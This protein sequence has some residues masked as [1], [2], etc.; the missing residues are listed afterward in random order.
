MGDVV[1]RVDASLEIGTGHVMRCLALAEALGRR[2]VTSRFIC[3]D[4][5]GHLAQRISRHGHRV[6]LL[7]SGACPPAQRASGQAGQPAHVAWLGA[8][9]KTDASQSIAMLADARPDWLVID[10]YA[11]DS[12]WEQALRPFCRR[13]MAID[14]LADRRHDVN[15]LLDQNLGRSADDYTGLLPTGSTVLAGARY[16]LL[17]P[18]FSAWRERSLA[19]RTDARLRRL[20]VSLGG[21]DKDNVTGQVLAALLKCELPQDCRISVVMGEQAPWLDAVRE[22][23]AA[24]PMVDV[25]VGVADVAALMADC[26]LAIGAAGTSAW[27]RCCVGLPT[28]LVVLAANQVPGARALRAAGAALLLGE[29][30]ELAASLKAAIERMADP[31]M[32]QAQ[33]KA[34][35]EVTDGLGTAR[36]VEALFGAA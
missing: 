33:Q 22:Q 18:E 31:A 36:I 29:G 7:A 5:E 4:H 6:D 30:D 34:C 12:T 23:A 32:L 2:G 1:F 21:V 26:D 3:R 8:D 20:L 10:H 11:L 28:L 16:A 9:W 15:L 14:D 13:M 24:M 19:R 17:R 25:Q 27:E 35:A